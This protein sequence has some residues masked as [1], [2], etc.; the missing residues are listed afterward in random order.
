[1]EK[2]I[3][4]RHPDI[5]SYDDLP[6][7]GCFIIFD[8]VESCNT[9]YNDY[10]KSNKYTYKDRLKLLDKY[11]VKVEYADDPANIN[12][13]N[14]EVSKWES[15]WRSCVVLA[16]AIFLL[17]ITFILVYLMRAYQN[18]LPEPEDCEQYIEVAF[19][20]VNKSN[21]DELNCVCMREGF[22]NLLSNSSKRSTCEDYIETY[23]LRLVV[24]I[25]VSFS[26]SM[27]N[28][29]IRI[30]FRKL[31]EFERY[32]S[33]SKEKQSIFEKQF[34]AVFINM[35]ILV[36][37]INADFQEIEVVKEISNG[38]GSL[39]TIF[40]NGDY[41]DLTR[42]WYTSVGLSF[43]ILV[44][45]TLFSN[46]VS[47]LLWEFIRLYKRRFSAKKQLLQADM[48][49][50]MIGGIFYI[51]SKYS[52]T[53][54]MIFL[55]SLYYGPL[56]LLLPLLWIYFSMQYWVDKISFLRFT[57]RP[58]HYHANLHRSMI[59]CLPIAS[60]LHCGMSWWAY[61][62]PTIYR[63]GVEQR[64]ENGDIKYYSED[65][66]FS[67]R[68]FN[69]NSLPFFILFCIF[70]V[71]YVSDIIFDGYL[72]K[73]VFRIN[74]NVDLNQEKYSEIKDKMSDFTEVS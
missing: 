17:L 12:W 56:P 69:E 22:F 46:I 35:A 18:Q 48:N 44:I 40:F 33:M 32:K 45:S 66:T 34:V 7:V 54:A 19:E 25:V 28:Y 38:L 53:L 27:I 36:L 70:F 23:I 29:I 3:R 11:N 42:S 21:E 73:K 61:G 50:A 47:T 39:G 43:L 60:M 30:V 14:L 5:K 9:C 20:E 6:L 71:S 63:K 37:L 58:P 57:R 55:G 13:E 41:D 64:N 74:Q 15:L 2:E 26:V 31:A 65:R 24:T 1:M 52:L 51:E 68:L 4:E 16:I 8:D 67:E 72:I 10:K 49:A 59:N 62:L